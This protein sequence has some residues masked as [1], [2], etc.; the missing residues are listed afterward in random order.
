MKNNIEQKIR[1]FIRDNFLMGE[2]DGNLSSNDSLLEK[3]IIDS[4][5]ILELVSFLEETFDIK[6]Q[7]EEL[8][9][10]NL[11]SIAFIVNYIQHKKPELRG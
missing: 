5:G 2:D 10:E 3:G 6:V 11:D 1:D 9:P 4:V 8:V 7:D